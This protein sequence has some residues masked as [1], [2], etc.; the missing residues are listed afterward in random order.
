MD[1]ERRRSVRHEIR[2]HSIFVCSNCSPVKGWA[3]DISEGG[4][5]FEYINNEGSETGQEFGLILTG[6]TFTFYLPD[7]PCKALYDINL[8]KNDPP[9]K[10]VGTRRCGAKFQKLEPEI[11]EKLT[12]LLS[13]KNMLQRFVLNSEGP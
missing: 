12:S 10:T 13:D 11:K 1:H 2:P 7:L 9:F 8:N 4:I 5:A 6:D 3:K